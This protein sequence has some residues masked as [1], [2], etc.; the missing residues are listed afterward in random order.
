M[1]NPDCIIYW[2]LPEQKNVGCYLLVHIYKQ[3]RVYYLDFSHYDKKK[4]REEK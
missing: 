1:R 4:R 2:I 3:M